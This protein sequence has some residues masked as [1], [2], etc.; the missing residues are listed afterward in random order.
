MCQSAFLA[1]ARVCVCVCV[2][3][4]VQGL[5]EK[6]HPRFREED[7]AT[8]ALAS[9]CHE[10]LPCVRVGWLLRPRQGCALLV[11]TGAWQ[12]VCS[13]LR[14]RSCCSREG[15]LTEEGS[16]GPCRPLRPEPRAAGAPAHHGVRCIPVASR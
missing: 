7:A 9:H 16:W 4:R 12:L 11:R 3:V 2:R 1:C 13:E 15:F 14:G 6:R 10:L 8:G 5:R